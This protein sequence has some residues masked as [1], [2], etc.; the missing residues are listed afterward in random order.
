MRFGSV[1]L[2]IQDLLMRYVFFYKFVWRMIVSDIDRS[3]RFSELFL[4][5]LRLA[6][7]VIR[8]CTMVPL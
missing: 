4:V 3:C 8:L 2:E 1:V 5:K 7:D 6:I